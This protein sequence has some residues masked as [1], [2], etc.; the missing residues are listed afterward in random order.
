MSSQSVTRRRHS[1]VV[2]QSSLDV[3]KTAKRRKAVSVDET[4]PP[5]S[6]PP[7]KLPRVE[8]SPLSEDKYP[9]AVAAAT[10]LAQTMVCK[11]SDTVN[12]DALH[13]INRQRQCN[14]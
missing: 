8:I 1:S 12:F 4:G 5:A 13:L 7:C 6:P 3:S 2:Q 9:A 14:G 11:L 10:S